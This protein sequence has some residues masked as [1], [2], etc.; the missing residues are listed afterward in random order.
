MLDLNLL[1][2]IFMM[3]LINSSSF[4]KQKEAIRALFQDFDCSQGHLVETWVAWVF[5]QLIGKV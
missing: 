1:C 5:V 2:T 3:C 4:D